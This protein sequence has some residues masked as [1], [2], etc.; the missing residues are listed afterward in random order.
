MSLAVSS[1][2][3]VGGPTASE[4]VDTLTSAVPTT[5]SNG[6]KPSLDLSGVVAKTPQ[7]S[8]AEANASAISSAPAANSFPTLDT[9][10]AGSA[11]PVL[12]TG[13]VLLVVGLGFASVGRTVFSSA[14]GGL[15]QGGVITAVLAAALSCIAVLSLF[16]AAV[17]FD[18]P[19]TPVPF[20]PVGGVF[21]VAASTF[22]SAALPYTT[23][24][25]AMMSGAPLTA[26]AF[27]FVRGAVLA[28]RNRSRVFDDQNPFALF[29]K[30]GDLELSERSVDR[31]L[32]SKKTAPQGVDIAIEA[33]SVI[34][35]DLVISR[36]S[37]TVDER[38][39]SPIAT[40]RIKD[41]S[42]VLFAGSTVLG[43]SAT[44]RVITSTETSCLSRIQ[45]LALPA[46]INGERYLRADDAGSIRATLLSLAF[47]SVAAA[48]SWSERT[49][50][51]SV[52]LLAGGGVLFASLFVQLRELTYAGR[53]SFLKS[54]ARSGFLLLRPETLS[55]LSKAS[56]V[57]FE[58]PVVDELSGNV[59]HD[60]ELLDDRIGEPE[61]CGTLLSLLG[62]AESSTL[63]S[64]AQYC[65]SRAS[66]LTP[67]RV[68]DMHEYEGKG[69][70]G[71]IRGIDITIGTEEFLVERGIV[72]QPSDVLPS[73]SSPTPSGVLFVAIGD[74][75]IGRFN[76]TSGPLSQLLTE[77]LPV[78][79][80]ASIG[81]SIYTGLPSTQ[82]PSLLVRAVGLTSDATSEEA[83]TPLP[84]SVSDQGPCNPC[85]VAPIP[86]DRFEL[87]L[88]DVAALGG[89]YT[90]LADLIL[91]SRRNKI[92][93]SFVHYGASLICIVSV[94]CIFVGFLSP[95]F[96]SLF[97]SLGAIVTA[98]G[99]RS[100]ALRAL[101]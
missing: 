10:R 99:Y 3:G 65:R 14:S 83:L 98:V 76:L 35:A 9:V 94:L 78:G 63:S 13:A 33:G 89:N 73:P 95:V 21:L 70:C 75:V 47:C 16:R 37:V 31:P 84:A 96:S 86:S 27:L 39:L 54:W 40:A 43:G 62:R 93:S 101:P 74:G 46:L 15:E 69:V 72:F 66:D 7:G 17:L 2:T 23:F 80:Q 48:I 45:D 85:V 8:G 26:G 91:S 67:E 57:S 6:A 52:T 24:S 38:C 61:I 34:P 22:L 29:G 60:L 55:N 20:A 50:D 100:I 82:N 90:Q 68:L 81:A 87:P 42:E 41:E 49:N 51:P 18:D 92:L 19:L 5:G 59:V 11:A 30:A 32:S 36:G 79:W 64:A 71:L 53:L 1:K 44:G 97:F 56:S 12:A 77:Q 88:A 58:F 25:S 28:A 4:T